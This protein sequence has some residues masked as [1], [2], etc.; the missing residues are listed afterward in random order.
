VEKEL[1]MKP[2]EFDTKFIA[3]LEAQTKTTVEGFDSWKKQ[4]RALTETAKAGPPDAVIKA[5]LPIRDLYPDY[6][7]P[8]SVYELLSDAYLAKGDKASAMTQLEKYS[9]IGGRSSM[10]VK[11]LATLQ[12][13]A[14]KKKEAAASLERLNYIY[15]F[16]EELHRRLGGLWMELGNTKGAVA[17]YAAVIASKPLDQAASRFNLARALRSD[18]RT[19]DAKEQLLLSLEAAPGYKPAQRLLLEM[20]GK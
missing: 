17:E 18:N 15:P 9:A 4:I 2:E 8:G 13:E 7:E 12:E 19:E 11:K 3:W 20:S 10:L 6:V 1:K 5:G 16:D 14:G